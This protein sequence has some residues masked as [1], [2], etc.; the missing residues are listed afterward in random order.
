[1]NSTLLV[2]DF[3]RA[4]YKELRRHLKEVNLGTL[5]VNEGQL[6]GL[7]PEEQRSYV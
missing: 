7:K 4:D 1:M 2:P 6:S 5:R 3:R